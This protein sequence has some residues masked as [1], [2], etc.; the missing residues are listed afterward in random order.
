MVVLN[1]RENE[2]RAFLQ[3]LND[4]RLASQG[5][6]AISVRVLA[7]ADHD[8]VCATRIL[9]N[10]LQRVGIT[11][12]VVPV[13]GNM[14]IIEH[15]QQLGEDMEL[16]SLVLLNCGASLDLQRH[17]DESEAAPELNCYVV[18]A[19]RP[20]HLANLSE[21]SPRVIVLDDDPIVEVT[22]RPTLDDDEEDDTLEDQE[23]S[24]GDQE[25]VWD[26]D[27][28]GGAAPVEEVRER[29]R[30][31]QAQREERRQIK[32]QRIHEYYMSSYYATPSAMS[33]FKMA[34]QHSQPSEELLWV[35]AVSLT[36]YY[37]LDLMPKLKYERM[38]WED[39]METLERSSDFGATQTQDAAPGLDDPNTAPEPADFLDEIAPRRASGAPP[40]KRRLRFEQDLR[41]TLYK[42]W[43]LEDAIMHSSYFYGV[44]E[45]HRDKGQRS[46]KNFFATAG[47]P[48]T[49]Y[50][51][52]YTFMMLPIRKA[53][54]DKFRDKGRIY[55]LTVERM[56]LSQ[57]VREL[58]LQ[59]EGNALYLH[60]LSCLDAVHIVISLL[61]AVPASL[62]GARLEHL[63][64]TDEG[65]LDTA[66][67]NELER[68][69]MVTN[70]WRAF[71]AVGCRE[72]GLLWQGISEATTMSK[73]VQS[74]ARLLKDSKALH[75]GAR[76]FRWCKIEQPP[77]TF[78][79][80]I[81]VRR[82]AVW[83]LHVF[84]MYRPKGEGPELPL[85]MIVRD[86]VRGTYLCV[87]AT[88]PSRAEQD[89]F[90]NRFRSVL[91]TDTTLRY[92][93][94]FFD[95]SCIEIAADDFDRFWDLMCDPHAG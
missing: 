56:F 26:P 36:G 3:V 2:G 43:T 28:P 20:M 32:R 49:D 4:I 73:A 51:Q 23:G 72:P 57:F 25:N 9:V 10:V 61:S 16:R 12:T 17:I 19:H 35:A 89:E 18:D 8:G 22:D 75:G 71:D 53:L 76:L 94:D 15:I 70:F 60:D 44:M 24:D 63:P 11:Y 59:E 27:A 88:P 65:N 38:V 66:A 47:I 41:L 7:A 91:R 5:S 33:I 13:T 74:L 30:L 92:R 58:G 14:E 48:P 40:E 29:K 64:Q 39:L 69:A 62:S 82:L 52:L 86:R 95:K 93:Y 45:L 21:R 68:Q 87:G 81:A 79:H 78:R 55:G 84:F 37:D 6:S 54:H 90:G 50:K 83:L 1:V 42:H 77:H 34:K 67:V 80:I 46:L 85:L 31:R